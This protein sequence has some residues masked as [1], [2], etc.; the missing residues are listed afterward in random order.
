MFLFSVC[1]ALYKLKIQVTQNKTLPLGLGG[2]DQYTAQPYPSPFH[3]NFDLICLVSA[4]A[5]MLT[6]CRNTKIYPHTKQTDVHVHVYP[7]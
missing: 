6:N 7:K 1:F 3:C 4:H 2:I 5:Q